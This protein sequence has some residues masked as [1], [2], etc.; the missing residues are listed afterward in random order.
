MLAAAAFSLQNNS[1]HEDSEA[2]KFSIYIP[3]QSLYVHS[4]D[5]IYIASHIPSL[6]INSKTMKQ[7]LP[8]GVREYT[9]TRSKRTD[10]DARRASR[11]RSRAVN[12]FPLARALDGDAYRC[13]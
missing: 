7:L 1:T 6:A 5:K 10:S 8:T 4:Q 9:Y 3:G 12:N 2:R 11:Y 13:N